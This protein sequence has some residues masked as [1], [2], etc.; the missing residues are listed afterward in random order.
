VTKTVHSNFV[1]VHSLKYFHQR[2][3]YSFTSGSSFPAGHSQREHSS[4]NHDTRD[5]RRRAVGG[6]LKES[7]TDKF[8]IVGDNVKSRAFVRRTVA[9]QESSLILFS[10]TRSKS[11]IFEQRFFSRTSIAAT[12]LRTNAREFEG[13]SSN[14]STA[15]RFTL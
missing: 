2:V 6:H 15:L 10:I 9:D 1:V 13:L 12:V 5:Q 7:L 8:D 4:G 14:L 11:G 3:F